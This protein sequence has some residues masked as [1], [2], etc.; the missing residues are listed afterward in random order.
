MYPAFNP[1]ATDYVSRCNAGTPLTVSIGAPSGTAVSVNYQ[2]WQA[3]IFNDTV[4]LAQGQETAVAVL[5]P[6]GAETAYYIRCLPSDFPN[7]TVTQPAPS[8]ADG[9]V[10]MVVGTGNPVPTSSHCTVFN[11][12]G[13]PVWWSPTLFALYCTVLPDGNIGWIF[14]GNLEEHNLDGS[15]KQMISPSTGGVADGHDLLLLPNGDYV[16]VAGTTRTVDLSA[17]GK[18]SSAL[19][20]D[21]VI[22]EF[23]STGT[24]VGSWDTY[25]HIP[26]TEWDPQ[27]RTQTTPCPTGGETCYDV[28]HWNSIEYTGS[29]FIVSYRHLDAVY[30][31]EESASHL[32]STDTVQWKLGSYSG[33]PTSG[34]TGENL[35]V[36]NDPVFTPS[37]SSTCT[38]TPDPCHFGG[39]HD[40][41]LNGD[42][43]VSLYDDGTGISPARAPRAVRYAI[44]TTHM[45]A[46]LV[47]SITD[48]A[49][50]QASICCGSAR[51]L[52]DGDWV[53]GWGGTNV[54][55]ENTSPDGSETLRMTFDPNV[56]IYRML[57]LTSSQ[58]NLD[59]L[60]AGMDAQYA[61]STTAHSETTTKPSALT[62]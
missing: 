52:A 24:L 28:Y 16:L 59:A 23:T 61:N 15:L 25:D 27:W 55:T 41:R 17:E 1:S 42:G 40:A 12:Q 36:T 51:K 4:S 48:A 44:D 18:S 6:S 3:G 34:L 57:P 53:I 39:Q 13:V 2:P 45:T 46:T 38:A 29:G 62:P 19:I 14:N 50:P 43:T 10:G 54:A 11:S 60:R 7:W 56:L 22:E 26:A 58:F 33:G 9:F 49:A 31:I 32:Q 21:P 35:T 37:D 30:N 47:E 8:Q 5:A 20:S